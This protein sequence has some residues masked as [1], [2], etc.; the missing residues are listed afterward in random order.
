M[1]FNARGILAMASSG[2]NTSLSQFFITYVPLP[3]LDG[4]YT[5][6]GKVIDGAEDGGVLSSIEALPVDEKGRPMRGG[7]CRIG[8]VE[9]HANPIA[10]KAREEGGLGR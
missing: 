8:R 7:E 3:H 10:D 6:F 2:P 5:I 9:V 1:Q 4:K